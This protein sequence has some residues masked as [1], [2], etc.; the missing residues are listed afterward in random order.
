M[1]NELNVASSDRAKIAHEGR[2][3]R[4][5]AAGNLRRSSEVYAEASELFRQM[6]MTGDFD[7]ARHMAE[8]LKPTGN[9][10]S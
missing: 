5:R 7:S 1:V 10:S 9:S 3:A 4:L 2:Q 8:A 6:Q